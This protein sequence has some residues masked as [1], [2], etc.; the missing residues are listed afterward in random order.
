MQEDETYDWDLAIDESGDLKTVAN[1]EDELLKDVAFR[2]ANDLQDVLGL[3]LT[4]TTMNRVRAVVKDSMTSDSRI[5]QIVSL[6]VERVPTSSNAV[7]IEA[8]VNAS[9]ELVDLIFTI[10]NNGI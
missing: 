1:T 8:E 4:P 2:A 9:G 5:S 3:P 10:D 6:D 7:Q